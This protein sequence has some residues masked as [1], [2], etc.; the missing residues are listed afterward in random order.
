V[1]P[2]PWLRM[3]ISYCRCERAEFAGL[4]AWNRLA[5]S[6]LDNAVNALSNDAPC[7]VV[8][9]QSPQDA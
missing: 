5:L 6:D 9:G 2:D 1:A 4:S 7:T 3:R 8:F